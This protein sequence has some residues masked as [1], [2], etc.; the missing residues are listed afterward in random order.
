MRSKSKVSYMKR[1]DAE[2]P[3]MIVVSGSCLNFDKERPRIMAFIGELEW[4]AHTKS[5]CE[6]SSTGRALGWDFF[7]IYFDQSFVEKLIEVYPDIQKQEG[8]TLEQEFVLWLSKQLKKR[9]LEYYLK[10]VEIPY[11][12]T[13]GFRLNPEYYRNEMDLEDLR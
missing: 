3:P 7:Q 5:D 13:G 11:Q 4:G 6:V 10:L 8:H 2:K 9:K 12:S 1:R